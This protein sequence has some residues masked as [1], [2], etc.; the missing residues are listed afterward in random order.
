MAFG[1][2]ILVCESSA[3]SEWQ[4]WCQTQEM[5]DAELK[6]QWQ[7]T[8][9]AWMYLQGQERG[10]EA[11]LEQSWNIQFWPDKKNTTGRKMFE[12]AK[13]D[14]TWQV[15]EI[16][17]QSVTVQGIGSIEWLLFD[18][19]AERYSKTEICQLGVP[20]S[21]NIENN[22]SL[23]EQAWRVNPWNGL[24]DKKWHS[25][26]L[27]LITN[28][29]DYSMK[30]MSRPLAK[31]GKPRA[32]FAESWRSGTSLSQLEKN[33]EAMQALYFANGMGLDNILRKRGRDELAS[34][35]SHQFQVTL[36][37]WPEQQSM[38]DLLQ[39]KSGYQYLMAQ[40][41][42]LEQLHYYMTEE[43][44]IELGIVIGFN[45]TDGD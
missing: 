37:T 28:Q 10:P 42:K 34:L 2:A 7:E 33:I 17:N 29:L 15:E 12:L 20:I 27:S 32:Y 1:T 13:Q 26:Y 9:S 31:P 44:A 25:E 24:D 5:Q 36:E 39:S 35:I 40:Y 14:K 22:A 38:F 4:A 3:S 19:S 11:A 45:A 6:A 41:N 30:K 18:S 16:A 21:Q 43:V 8:I 23:I